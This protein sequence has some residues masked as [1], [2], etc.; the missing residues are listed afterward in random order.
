METDNKGLAGKKITGLP[1]YSC[2]EGMF[3]GNVRTLLVD[4]K[5]YNVQG[6]ILERRRA[7]KDERI[8]PFSA[9]H[10]FGEDGITVESANLLER[11]GQSSHYIRAIRHPLNIVGSRVFTT[12]GRTLGKVEDYRFDKKSGIICGLEIS[13]DGFFKVR[14]LV[15]GRHLLAISDNT[16]MLHEE[17]PDDAI[18]LENT[19]LNAAG[20]MRDRAGELMQNT[21]QLTKRLS[22]NINERMNRL[23][24]QEDAENML[25]TENVSSRGEGDDCL[26]CPVPDDGTPC[27]T[28]I[29]ETAITDKQNENTPEA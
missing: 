10:C 28:D 25:D 21:A 24:K 15:D 1:V 19:L 3:L 5:D 26:P 18:P 4:T 13:P 22:T 12:A 2:K 27:E 14:T 7:A 23:K 8:L 16:I 20:S 29:S 9:V 11:I 6:F 17:A